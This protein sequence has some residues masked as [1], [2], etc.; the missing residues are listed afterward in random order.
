MNLAS[1]QAMKGALN[2][3]PQ[4]VRYVL[5]LIVGM[6]IG[7][8]FYPTKSLEEKLRVEYEQKMTQSE[9]AH[10][11][12]E[13]SLKESLVLSQKQSKDLEV[14]TSNKIAKLTTENSQLKSKKTETYYKIVHPDGTIEVRS[15]KATETDQSNQIVV[16]VK[17]E[18]EQKVKELETKYQEIHK[19]RV[20]ALQED[21]TR[22]EEKYQE[23]IASLQKDKTVIT[24]P[25]KYGVEV[26]YLSNK[27]YYGHVNVDVFGPV[28]LGLHTQTNF[29]DNNAVGAG[30]GI[31]F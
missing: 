17:Q 27:D 5:V 21:F 10:K 22:K 1:L 31:R 29:L 9:E 25:K 24:N 7:A 14:S 4:W 28:F 6:A 15:Q 11:H 2:N 20:Q 23:T 18:Y 30:I 16:S 13:E 8:V 26:G 12:V 3:S 19:E